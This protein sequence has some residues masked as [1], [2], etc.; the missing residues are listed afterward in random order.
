MEYR[1]SF[2]IDGLHDEICIE[3]LAGVDNGAAV[4]ERAEES[5]NET[6][7]VEEGRWTADDVVSS[8]VQTVTHKFAVV[9]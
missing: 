4:Y 2:G 1:A 8:Q 9:N 6:E 3:L 5:H 7:A